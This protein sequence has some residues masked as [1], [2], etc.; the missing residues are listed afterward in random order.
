MKIIKKKYV[1]FFFILVLFIIFAL[2]ANIY[3]NKKQK[4]IVKAEEDIIINLITN[5]HP[6]LPWSFK[7]PNKR[8]FVKPGEVKVIEYIVENL[9]DE[10]TTGVATFAY[11][12][13]QFGEYIRKLNCFCYDAQT[14]KSNQKNKYSFVLLIDP[15][16][17]KDSK[18]K[19]IKEVTIQFTFFEYKDYKN[20][21]N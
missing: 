7:A 11:H 1:L 16:V 12:P 15:E 14:L 9:E 4:D 19:N 17:T 2:F 13:N 21:D 8:I 10:E 6:K 3:L 18:T 20:N 5:V